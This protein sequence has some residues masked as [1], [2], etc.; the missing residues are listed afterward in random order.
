MLV[1]RGR[2]SPHRRHERPLDLDARGRAPGVH[3]PGV[4]VAALAGQQQLTGGVPVEDGAERDQ[5]VDPGRPL[6]HEHPHRVVVAQP[7]AGG[8][9]VGEVEVG[10]VGIAAQHGGHAALGP[11]R[12]G[13]G[14]L[15]LGQDADPQPVDVGR[16][17][18]GR[19]AGDAGPEHQQVEDRGIAPT[20]GGQL[21]GTST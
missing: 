8:Q 19:E 6:V 20:G 13:L 2:G 5:L 7:G 9:G 3:H 14:Q 1:Q 15:A 11:P 4:R 18:R 17:H 21:A 16:P 12:R 10:R